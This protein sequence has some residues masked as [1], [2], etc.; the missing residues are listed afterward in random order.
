MEL[1]MNK[2]KISDVSEADANGVRWLHRNS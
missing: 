2:M 1:T